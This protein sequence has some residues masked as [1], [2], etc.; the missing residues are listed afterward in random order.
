MTFQGEQVWSRCPAPGPR[1]ADGHLAVC[2]IEP[3]TFLL[4]H[5]LFRPP[6]PP[7]PDQ[8]CLYRWR[9]FL[10]RF[11]K[12]YSTA[13]VSEKTVPSSFTGENWLIVKGPYFISWCQNKLQTFSSYLTNTVRHQKCSTLHYVPFNHLATRRNETLMQFG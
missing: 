5:A 11:I 9:T 4:R 3:V 12:Q 8:V 10:L 6:S 2:R 13:H 1:A 7:V